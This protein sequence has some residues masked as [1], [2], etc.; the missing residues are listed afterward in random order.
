[1]LQME[2]MCVNGAGSISNTNTLSIDIY[3]AALG[4]IDFIRASIAIIEQL[5][6]I[7]CWLTFKLGIRDRKAQPANINVPNV[8][9][10]IF[11]NN[12]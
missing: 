10:G 4:L 3:K 2:L 8:N 12:H 7:T 9:D 5:N 11:T 1:M 6:A